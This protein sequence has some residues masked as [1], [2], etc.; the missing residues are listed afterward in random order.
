MAWEVQDVLASDSSFGVAP[1]AFGGFASFDSVLSSDSP[2]SRRGGSPSPLLGSYRVRPSVAV[3]DCA[4][5]AA[6][7]ASPRDVTRGESSPRVSSHATKGT[8]PRSPVVKID[9]LNVTFP[10]PSHLGDDDSPVD[11]LRC[12]NPLGT[13]E[14]RTFRQVVD[15]LLSKPISAMTEGK[16]MFGFTRSFSLEIRLDDGATV[17]VGFLAFGGNS[18]RGKWF[19]QLNGKGCG[20]VKDW[21]GMRDFLEELEA[22]I[23]R[24]DLAADFL[25]GE[26]SVD[27]AVALYQEGAFISRGRNPKLDVQGGWIDGSDD[28]RTLYIGRLENG[29]MLC[30]YEKGKQL[31]M[32]ASDWTRY[33]VRL[34][35]KDRVIPLDVLTNPDKYFAGAYPALAGM[36]DSAAQEIPTQREELKGALAHGVYHLKRC[37]GKLIH[38]TLTATDC[39]AEGLIEEIRVLGMP[40]RLDPAAVS[41]GIEWHVLKQQV[42]SMNHEYAS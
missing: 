38:Q 23:S 36:L 33:E 17:P 9:W 39:D 27:D 5:R 34:G 18:Q 8:V 30:A 14:L 40:N 7:V 21:A 2:P 16:G 32:K 41:A 13:A 10:R 28:G 11:L 25:N 35:N 19:F 37:Y 26:Y 4:I 6:A 22:S 42:R 20:L 31:N 29:K 12:H 15:G 1:T 3:V 24:T